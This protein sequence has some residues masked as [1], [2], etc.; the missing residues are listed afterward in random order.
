M[1]VLPD[2]SFNFPGTSLRNLD[3]VAVGYGT[4]GKGFQFIY[5][6]S[7]GF[8][9]FALDYTGVCIGISRRSDRV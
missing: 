4:L 7:A 6:A 2:N 9:L 5:L 1:Y 3:L 8:Y